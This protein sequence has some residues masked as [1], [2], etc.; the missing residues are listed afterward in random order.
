MVPVRLPVN[1]GPA[2]A[3]LGETENRIEERAYGKGY[4][5][6]ILFFLALNIV[7]TLLFIHKVNRKVYDEPYNITDVH[8]YATRGLNAVSLRAHTNPPGPTGFYWMATAVRLL[9]GDE[10]RDA[11][12]GAL[13]A[14]VV[15]ACGVFAFASYSCFPELWYGALLVALVFPHAVE[16][17]ATILTEGPSLLFAVL[18]ALLWTGFASRPRV[19]PGTLAAGIL[20]GLS[21]GVAVTC[22]QYNLALLPAAGVVALYQFWQLR[23]TSKEKWIWL[24]SAAVT[25]M[26]AAIPVV[27][28]VMVW[29]G[30]SSPGMATMTSYSN[31]QSALGLNFSR[32]VIA[33][34]Y[35]AVYLVPLSF[36]AMVTVKR[37]MRVPG[38][39]AAVL[40]GTMA[41]YFGD[42]LLTPGPLHTV[43]G[44]L[45]RKP[46]IESLMLGIVA[47]VAI[48]N[49]FALCLLMWEK[50][51]MALSCPPAG[52][53]LFTILFFMA[54][55]IGV[56]GNIPFYDRYLLNE[57]PYL[58]LIAFFL[59]PRL[60]YPRFMA[61]A[62]LSLGGQVILWRYAFGS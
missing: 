14:W 27:M 2:T 7:S 30:F 22:R 42:S 52:L 51:E 25:L 43:L 15:L 12:I 31:W 53:A 9:G 44:T 57:A 59:L 5:F 11:R 3:S 54:E 41:G 21:M 17:T 49:L 46:V 16:A 26:V 35:V 56:G 39:V 55:Q 58:G 60:T 45:G 8:A 28:L 62:V 47:A 50:R 20:G 6:P 36:P 4:V 37:E 19:T 61:L 18:G 38:L 48:Y 10:L 32:P 33:A 1:D 29:K 34:F 23:E 24:V 40:G 13:L